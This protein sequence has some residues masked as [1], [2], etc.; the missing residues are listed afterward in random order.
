MEDSRQEENIEHSEAVDCLSF[1]LVN[2]LYS[3]SS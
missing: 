3:A 1:D 2:I